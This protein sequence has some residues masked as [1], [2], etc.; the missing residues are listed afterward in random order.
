MLE[1]VSWCL[2]EVIAFIMGIK[3]VV[4]HHFIWSEAPQHH[5]LDSDFVGHI[6]GCSSGTRHCCLLP[7]HA[8]CT[9]LGFAVVGAGSAGGRAGIFHES[10]RNNPPI[11]NN[12]EHVVH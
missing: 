2:L 12:F 9:D 7:Q 11:S 3:Y 5:Y 4:Y 6:L 10:R 1:T 8:E